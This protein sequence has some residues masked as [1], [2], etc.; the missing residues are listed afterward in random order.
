MNLQKRNYSRFYRAL[1]PG[2]A[3][4]AWIASRDRSSSIPDA[5][6]GCAPPC[7]GYSAAA[8]A[9]KGTHPFPA[10]RGFAQSLGYPDRVL[11]IVS[12]PHL[13]GFKKNAP[14]HAP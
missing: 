3:L 10:G 9:P 7:G 14:Q 5:R 8:A 13:V 4:L 11:L 2:G 12:V 1:R 6:H